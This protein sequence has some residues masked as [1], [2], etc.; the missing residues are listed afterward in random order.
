MS[1]FTFHVHYTIDSERFYKRLDLIIKKLTTMAGELAAIKE[2]L[3]LSDA[4][5]DI[6]STATD[7][8]ALDV[9]SIKAKLE[10]AG[11]GSIDPAGVADLLAIVT[12]QDEK[13]ATVATKLSDL[14]AQTDP[15]A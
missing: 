15:N 12:A 1:L 10:A 3:A 5:I 6:L 11:E 2:K 9:A 8:L 13:L 4:K 7:G 14:D